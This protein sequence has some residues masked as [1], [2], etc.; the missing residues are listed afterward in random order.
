MQYRTLEVTIAAWDGASYEIIARAGQESARQVAR[1]PLSPGG[2]QSRLASVR[3]ALSRIDLGAGR[4]A[5]EDERAVEDFAGLLFRFAFAG[6]VRR[7]FE[8]ER[9]AAVSQWQGL[10]LDLRVTAPDLLAVP[11]E[12]LWDILAFDLRSLRRGVFDLR[13]ERGELARPSAPAGEDGDRTTRAALRPTALD[14]GDE[15]GPAA[16]WLA[17]AEEAFYSADFAR[18]IELFSQALAQAP[19]LPQ[20]RE[21]LERARDC[22][23]RR[24]PASTVPPRAASEY[25]RAWE[26]YTRYRFDEAARWL[27]EAW[28]LAK[29]WG[30]AEWPEARDF[31]ARIERS[32]AGY[33]S[34]CKALACRRA[35]DL[36]GAR[37]ALAQAYR[38]D[39]LVIY[40][41]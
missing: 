37:E 20:A 29:D 28:L 12:V 11:W 36:P 7:L 23:A 31:H 2:L 8:E 10:R 1:F 38:A 3:R 39:P 27:D 41:L 21:C 13:I 17:Q 24:D 6:E 26:A 18:A 15:P 32:R 9:A 34:Y 4:G 16:P 14:A 22:L 40:L 33:A 5:G 35:G 19:E 30:I 25:R